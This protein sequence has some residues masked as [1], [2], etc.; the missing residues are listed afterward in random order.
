MNI[1]FALIFYISSKYLNK[2]SIISCLYLLIIPVVIFYDG[3]WLYLITSIFLSFLLLSLFD[4]GNLKKFALFFFVVIFICILTN[5]RV[6]LSSGFVN[7]INSQRGEH[8][9][10]GVLPKFLHNKIDY[11]HK[12]IENFDILLSPVAIFANGFWHKLNPYFPLG[13]LFPWDIYFLYKFISTRKEKSNIYFWLA[14]F[15]LLILSGLLYIDQA[16]IFSLTIVLFLAIIISKGY[17]VTGRK[18]ALAVLLI[19]LIYIFIQLYLTKYFPI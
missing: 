19:N 2:L 10:G 4:T 11:V 1:I 7:V 3:N 15:V 14:L 17:S 12:F 8:L 5:P 9:V 18:S 16:M 13:Y 6:G